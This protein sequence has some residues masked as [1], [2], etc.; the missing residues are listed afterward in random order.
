[1]VFRFDS[2]L[3][4][5]YYFWILHS[6]IFYGAHWHHPADSCDISMPNRHAPKSFIQCTIDV[7]PIET[8]ATS[9]TRVQEDLDQFLAVNAKRVHTPSLFM[10]S[11]NKSHVTDGLGCVIEAIFI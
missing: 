9:A 6:F 7:K 5:T 4:I 1:M 10:T 11:L 8:L 3:I 2:T